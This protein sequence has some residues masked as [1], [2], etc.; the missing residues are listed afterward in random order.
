MTHHVHDYEMVFDEDQ[1]HTLNY[2]MVCRCG[3]RCSTMQEAYDRTVLSQ[4]IAPRLRV[5]DMLAIVFASASAAFL[6]AVCLVR[7]R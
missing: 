3:D 4:G 7:F 1:P 2:E 5:R 6:M